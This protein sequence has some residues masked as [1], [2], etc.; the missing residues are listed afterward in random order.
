MRS[1]TAAT[2][3][4]PFVLPGQ[5]LICDPSGNLVVFSNYD[6]GRV[7]IHVDLDIPDLRI[8]LLSYEYAVVDVSG[9]Y[10]GNV[11]HVYFSGFNAN[12]D[13]CDLGLPIGNTVLGAPNA[14]V[15]FFFA[16][17]AGLYNPYGYGAMICCY[18]CDT[19]S[20]QG[21]CNTPDQVVDHFVALSGGSLRSHFTQYACWEGMITLSQGGNC[22]LG[23]VPTAVEAVA[24]PGIELWPSPANDML[25]VSAD[26]T[27]GY[28]ASIH[29]VMGRLVG[30]PAVL[31]GDRTPIPVGALPAGTW[32]LRLERAGEVDWR[33]FQVAR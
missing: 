8:G 23:V 24:E 18:S 15:E 21:G 17:P 7:T 27:M 13:H 30:L 12:N 5:G 20:D 3:L 11:T 26:A 2:L 22:C 10:A 28:R 4:L 1:I 14:Q 29:D 6:G 25:F 16:P 33:R 31:V 19:G 32:L 9:P